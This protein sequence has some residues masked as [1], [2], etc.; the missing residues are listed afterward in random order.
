MPAE[1]AAG[2][3]AANSRDAWWE[4]IVRPA[5]S[6]RDLEEAFALRYRVYVEEY[7]KPY[8]GADHERRLLS[9]EWDAHSAVLVAERDGRVAGTIRGTL[10]SAPGFAE[11]HADVFGQLEEVRA[12][13][14][15]RVACGSRLVVDAAARGHSRLAVA[16]MVA[17]YAW[18]VRQGAVVCLCHTVAPL[19][20]L[21]EKMGWQRR[22]EPFL[23]A[24]SS[25]LQ[26]P[27]VLVVGD[28][29]HL[30]SVGSPLAGLAVEV[31]LAPSAR[32]FDGPSVSTA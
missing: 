27:M 9:D 4:S 28:Q 15:H 29:Q 10:G 21:M 23:H 30:Q 6:D 12:V 26:Y 22:G 31:S 8:P 7:G 11:A 5:T 32:N 24:D 14:W 20:P 17:I 18:A 25:T 13:G 1:V 2:R 3:R 16:L 19:L